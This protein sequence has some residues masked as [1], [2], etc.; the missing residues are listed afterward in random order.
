MSHS[1]IFRG[2]PDVEQ[3]G[4][5]YLYEQFSNSH[6][7]GMAVWAALH[8]EYLG[9]DLHPLLMMMG[10]LQPLWD[11]ANDESVKREH[12]LVLTST[13]D[14]WMCRPHYV[15]TIADAYDVFHEDFGA[16][17]KGKVWHIPAMADCFRRLHEE[18][19]ESA[20]MVMVTSISGW[21]EE[22]AWL[23]PEEQDI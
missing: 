16:Q 10:D 9:G 12:R 17:M 23:W 1:A 22:S 19:P 7:F 11:L 14:G 20:A 15:P 4:E 21:A 5:A 13:F 18:Y 2:Q 3:A 8:R 6:G